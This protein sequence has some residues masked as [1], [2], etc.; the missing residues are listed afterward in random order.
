VPTSN[1]SDE[2]IAQFKSLALQARREGDMAKAREYL[3]Q[4]KVCLFAC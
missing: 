2:A 4:M 1:N 3:I